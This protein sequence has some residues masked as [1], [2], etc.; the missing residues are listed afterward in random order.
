MAWRLQRSCDD[1]Q[2]RQVLPDHHRCS[3][4]LLQARQ[5]LGR[6]RVRLRY[7]QRTGSSLSDMALPGPGRMAA[8]GVRLIV[9]IN[10]TS[11]GPATR[12]T[13]PRVRLTL[14]CREA[15]VRGVNC[16]SQGGTT[17]T[18]RTSRRWRSS[19][20][21]RATCRQCNRLKARWT[22]VLLMRMQC[23]LFGSLSCLMLGQVR[24]KNKRYAFDLSTSSRLANRTTVSLTYIHRRSCGPSVFPGATASFH[25]SESTYAM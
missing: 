19:R 16:S 21:K 4:Q 20:L 2:Q 3:G 8:S 1:P 10:S 22:S 5:R 7:P 25:R 13:K 14:A 17:S 23:K 24:S 15:A 12:P 6:H 9:A 11:S 18:T